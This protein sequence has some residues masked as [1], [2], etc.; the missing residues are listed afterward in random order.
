IN[1]APALTEAR[2]GVALQSGS[3]AA[4]ETA[5]VLLMNN[6][7]A[8]LAESVHAA[9]RSQRVILFNFGG[10]L[11]VDVVGIALASAGFLTPLLA[12]LVHVGSELAFILNSARLF[13][14]ARSESR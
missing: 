13:A 4:A 8:E 10:T 1:D 11:A 12:A 14:S 5:D 3:E 6:D 7:L 2:V 9:R